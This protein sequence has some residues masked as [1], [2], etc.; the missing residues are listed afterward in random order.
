MSLELSTIADPQ[1]L[2]YPGPH[3]YYFL[4]RVGAYR[5]AELAPVGASCRFE[6]SIEK[7]CS[8]LNSTDDTERDTMRDCTADDLMATG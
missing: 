1:I 8:V 3:R 7:S 4:A 2:V 5:G 6:R